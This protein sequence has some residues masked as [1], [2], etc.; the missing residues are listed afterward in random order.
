[1]TGNANCA[2]FERVRLGTV[3]EFDDGEMHEAQVHGG[4]CYSAIPTYKVEVDGDSLYAYLPPAPM[5]DEVEM[6]RKKI[7]GKDNRVFVIC[8]GGAA[9]HAAAE[10]LR[11]EGFGGR[12]LIFG[13]EVHLPYYRPHLTKRIETKSYDQV[14]A[15]QALRPP[16]WYRANQVE[17]Y[18]GKKVTEVNHDVNTITLEDGSTV[19]YD[20]VLVATGSE[21][22]KLPMGRGLGPLS[23][24][25]TLRTADDLGEV[26]KHIKPNTRVVLVG[27][28]F[29]GCEMASSLTNKK[30][31]VTVVTDM[32][33]PMNN[34]VGTRGGAALKSL[35]EKNGVTVITGSPVKS[36]N[37][38]GGRVTQ[39]VTAKGVVDADVVIEGVGARVTVNLLKCAQKNRDGTVTVDASMRCKGCPDNVFAAGDIVTYPYHLDGT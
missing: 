30:A 18:G 23:N 36:Y 25:F 12:I 34:I 7:S 11:L 6:P 13:D 38:K 14:A 26:V 19:K 15:E 4:P 9:A 3:K 10:T 31:K 33:V 2:K 32:E 24:L 27:A 35:L 5:S 21:A 29:I 17:Y 39:V 8:G 22:V 16:L 20:K 1:M 28:N 37:A